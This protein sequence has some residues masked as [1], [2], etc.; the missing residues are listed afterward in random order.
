MKN[1]LLHTSLVCTYLHEDGFK[2]TVETRTNTDDY[3]ENTIVSI[4]HGSKIDDTAYLVHD[5]EYKL[6]DGV[7]E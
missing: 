7:L 2:Y 3:V 6:K 1:R 4:L 5:K